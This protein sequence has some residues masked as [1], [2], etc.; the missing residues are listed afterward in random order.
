LQPEEPCL[1][2]GILLGLQERLD[3]ILRVARR[4]DQFM[5]DAGGGTV[6]KTK[7]RLKNYY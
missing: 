4:L 6:E 2:V 5:Q 3:H 7:E 1:D